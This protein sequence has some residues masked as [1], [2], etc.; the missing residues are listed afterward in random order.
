MVI[1]GINM[2]V[3]NSGSLHVGSKTHVAR[4]LLSILLLSFSVFQFFWVGLIKNNSA[5]EIGAPTIQIG[6][7]LVL[8]GSLGA[9]AIEIMRNRKEEN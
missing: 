6:L 2:L 7:Y 8:L 1:L 4:Y 9:V 5:G 3:L